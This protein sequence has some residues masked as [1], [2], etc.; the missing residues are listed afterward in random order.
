MTPTKHNNNLVLVQRKV[1]VAG[2]YNSIKVWAEFMQIWASIS[3]NRGR[4]IFAGDEKQSVI[5]HTIRADFLDAENVT[6]EMRFVYNDTHTYDPVVGGS[7]VF[8]I[9]AVMPD[10]D[11]KTDVMIQVGLNPL[12]Y[13]DLGLNVSQ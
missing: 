6:E 12:R 11:H 2:E 9:L 5:T 3:P 1:E 4:E 10:I 7:K 8:D 13:E